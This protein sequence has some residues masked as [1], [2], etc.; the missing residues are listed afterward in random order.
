[1]TWRLQIADKIERD[2]SLIRIPLANIER[3]LAHG[4]TEPHRLVQWREVLLRAQSDPEG[5]RALLD[6]LRAKSGEAARLC[7][8]DVFPGVIDIQERRTLIRECAYS[9]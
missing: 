4:H 6:T 3:W 5:L 9:H 8:F 7:D 2:P 1:M